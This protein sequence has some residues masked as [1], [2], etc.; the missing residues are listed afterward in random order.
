M[1]AMGSHILQHAVQVS[2]VWQLVECYKLSAHTQYK[3]L[4]G[5]KRRRRDFIS[6]GLGLGLPPAGCVTSHAEK[7]VWP[8]VWP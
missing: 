3:E 1:N 6:R 7:P 4:F 2:A 8:P 5:G